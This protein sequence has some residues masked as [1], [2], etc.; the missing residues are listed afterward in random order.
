MGSKGDAEIFRTSNVNRIASAD[1]LDHYIKVANPSAWVVLGAALALMTGLVIWAVVA[2]IPITVNTTGVLVK[3]GQAAVCWVDRETAQ[4]I[5]VTNA[6][7]TVSDVSVKSVEILEPPMSSSEVLKTLG[8]DFYADSID[9]SDWNYAIKL[10][11]E[12][13]VK[14][15]NFTIKA[16]VGDTQLV[17]V[18]IVVMEPHPINIALGRY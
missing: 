5:D 4:M 14:T 11:L 9:L 2:V 17:P 12:D 15:S 3:E 18:S 1:E 13:E 6:K 16:L 10:E 8:S 7:A